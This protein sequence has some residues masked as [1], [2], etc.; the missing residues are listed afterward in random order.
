[1]DT[2][3]TFRSQA[4]ALEREAANRYREFEGWFIDR[5]LH[6]LAGRC[7][8]LGVAHRERCAELVEANDVIEG[9]EFRTVMHAWL[10]D[11]AEV[12]AGEVFYSLAGPRQLLEVA[13]DG[14]LAA[15]RF[16]EGVCGMP[17]SPAIQAGAMSLAATAMRCVGQVV[18]AIDEVT[19]VDWEAVIEN[20]GGPAL[21]LGAERRL[22][23]SA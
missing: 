17:P 19:P 12:G 21:A 6:D 23:A 5:H 16:Y 8:K 4:L 11:G 10:E 1:M 14:E 15:L 2:T 3:D 22:R 20:G 7:R 18:A 9:G 13:L